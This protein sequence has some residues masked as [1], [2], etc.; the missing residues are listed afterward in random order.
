MSHGDNHNKQHMVEAAVGAAAEVAK[1]AGMMQTALRHNLY[2]A[3]THHG[4]GQCGAMAARAVVA[5]APVVAA[6]A[7]TA[8]A[9]AI[10]V[11]VV[12]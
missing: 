2:H 9:I 6:G 8:A 12:H 11:V 10:P 7:A 5:A 4:M 3:S 1:Q